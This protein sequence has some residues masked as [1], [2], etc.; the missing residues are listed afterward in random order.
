[1]VVQWL[2][3][4]RWV[5]AGSRALS[6]V[7]EAVRVPRCWSWCHTRLGA[8]MAVGHFTPA[9]VPAAVCGLGP[10]GRARAC[11]RLCALGI[12]RKGWRPWSACPVSSPWASTAARSGLLDGGSSVSSA[13]A[14]AAE[15]RWVP[16]VPEAN[17][18]VQKLPGCPEGLAQGPL[19][20]QIPAGA[21]AAQRVR[22]VCGVS[23]GCVAANQPQHW[24]ASCSGSA[25][26]NSG[27][28]GG[29][30]KAHERRP[31]AFLESGSDS[32]C[33]LCL[34]GPWPCSGP[35]PGSAAQGSF[36]VG[37]RRPHGEQR[38]LN[39]GPTH[40]RRTPLAASTA[41]HRARAAPTSFPRL[42]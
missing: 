30:G 25:G 14:F 19:E 10:S 41:P 5:T 22:R 17:S 2:V 6:G 7:R 38:G 21:V 8:G 39:P 29:G 26:A 32:S 33:F 18:E 16:M 36:R 13:S 35:T 20:A 15:S 4:G 28:T 24:V 1:M 9:G 40:S 31:P 12:A 34:L 11:S 42:T 23:G 3:W 27:S 37:L